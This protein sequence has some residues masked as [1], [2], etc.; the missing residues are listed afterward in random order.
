MTKK[1]EIENILLITSKPSNR[2]HRNISLAHEEAM[3]PFTWVKRMEMEAVIFHRRF[4]GIAFTAMRT[5]LIKGRRDLGAWMR[6]QEPD[7]G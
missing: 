6:E 1:R 4:P 2:I 3:H 7:A 5:D